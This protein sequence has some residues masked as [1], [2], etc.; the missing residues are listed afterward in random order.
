V[1]PP[2]HAW[3][4][5]SISSL[6]KVRTRE[7]GCAS[8][9]QWRVPPFRDIDPWCWS[10]NQAIWPQVHLPPDLLSKTT[11]KT[12]VSCS[13]LLL[14]THAANR[15]AHDTLWQQYVCC[16]DP[17]L[18]KQPSEKLMFAFSFCLPN[19]LRVKVA[20][21]PN[22]LDLIC[23]FWGIKAVCSPFPGNLIRFNRELN[24]LYRLPEQD[25]LG[26]V[27]AIYCAGE[28]RSDAPARVLEKNRNSSCIN[29]F[30]EFF[31]GLVWFAL[32]F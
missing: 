14:I 22:K 5:T 30:F 12:K 29:E 18:I 8:L 4:R 25:V 6:I 23:R 19:C 32:E 28:E 20:V 31:N 27:G 24:L 21:A 9:P 11:V 13:F 26:H 1:T 10:A 3:R 7:G 15:I 16:L 2:S 17:S